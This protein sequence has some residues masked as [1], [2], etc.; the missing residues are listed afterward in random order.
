MR[1]AN[2]D[3]VSPKSKTGEFVL[4][5]CNAYG[6]KLLWSPKPLKVAHTMT[7]EKRFMQLET[8]ARQDQLSPGPFSYSSQ[9]PFV[10]IES[11]INQSHHVMN[12]PIMGLPKVK[13][14]LQKH[15]TVVK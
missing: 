8:K 12:I 10:T 1:P 11:S 4:P 9:H 2:R 7:F 6:T 3:F 15:H 5:T 14:R 13:K